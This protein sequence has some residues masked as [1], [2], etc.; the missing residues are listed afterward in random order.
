MS[1]NERAVSY[2]PSLGGQ[3]VVE[4]VMIRGPRGAAVCVRKP[5]GEIVCRT[6]RSEGPQALR[7]IPIARGILALGDTMSQGMRAMLWSAQ[8]AA[9]IDPQEPAERQVRAVTAASLGLVSALFM[10]GPAIVTR[11]MERKKRSSRFAPFLEG[12]TRVTALVGYLRAMGRVPQ[13][14]RL[15]A[16]HAAEH[17]AIQAYEAGQPL[18][19]ETLHQYPNAHVRCGTSF[20]LTTT[21]I[22][23]FVYAAV[24]QR[25]GSGRILSRVLLMPVIAGLSYEAIRFGSQHA[26]SPLAL[27]F[28]P[29]LMLQSLTTRDPDEGQMEVALAAVRAALSLHQS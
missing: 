28:R 8:I 12:A 1:S 10:I 21:L 19:V 14:Q 4:G 6:D 9:G 17:R 20:L 27:L 16:Y 15:F 24:G 26:D 22:S 23:S 2:P 18:E 29:N 5:N 3:A 13:A 7:G 25:T 11:R